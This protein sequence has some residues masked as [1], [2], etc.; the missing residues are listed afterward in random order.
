M[1]ILHL[2]DLHF[3]KKLGKLSFSEDQRFIS[4]KIF[5]TID[6]RNIDAVMICGDIYDKSEP[7]EEAVGMFNDFLV[8]LKKRNIPVMIIAGNHDSAEKLSFGESIFQYENIFISPVYDGSVKKVTLKDE[9][10]Q[11]NFYLMPFVKPAHVKN[12]FPDEK[13]STYTDALRIAIEHMSPDFTLRNVILSHQFVTGADVSGSEDELSVGG[14]SAVDSSVYMG[15]DYAAL[16]HIH[17]MQAVSGDNIRYCGSPMKFSFNEE[18]QVKSFTVVE[19]K[20]KGNITVEVLP[21]DMY[22]DFVTIRGTYDELKHRNENIRQRDIVHA[23]LLDEDDVPN[24]FSNLS[25]AYPG[26]VSLN[27]DNTR[28]RN[29][30]VINGGD[31][32]SDITPSELFAEFFEL[33]NGRPMTNEQKEYID[34]YIENIWGENR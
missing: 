9:F 31:I 19:L 14:I 6:S 21:V 18:K 5:E 10:G 11:V 30:A 7:S 13:I 29:T 23:V 15:F 17:G 25:V 2:G 22:R 16:G 1:K 12:C 33:R 8:E 32:D 4:G 24:A 28:T 26:I 34:N 20:E 27:Y 3:G